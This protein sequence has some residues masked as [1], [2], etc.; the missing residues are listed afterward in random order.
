MLR[1]NINAMAADISRSPWLYYG[2]KYVD[3]ELIHILRYLS[4]S[5]FIFPCYDVTPIRHQSIE[6]LYVDL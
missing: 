6:V 1:S 4:Q 3:V 2:T 5:L